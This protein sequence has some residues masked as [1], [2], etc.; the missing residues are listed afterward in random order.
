MLDLIEK[1]KVAFKSNTKDLFSC[2]VYVFYQCRG[3]L[4]NSRQMRADKNETCKN[5]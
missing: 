3:L 4:S 2:R 1:S 5:V